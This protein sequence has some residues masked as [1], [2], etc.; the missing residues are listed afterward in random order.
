ML[1]T[2]KINKIQNTR[3]ME[4]NTVEGEFVRQIPMRNQLFACIIEIGEERGRKSALE[5]ALRI[6]KYRYIEA[7]RVISYRVLSVGRL[8][9]VI[10]SPL[11][12]QL[13]GKN[14]L[15]GSL[16]ALFVSKVDLDSSTSPILED[17]GGRLGR[18]LEIFFNLFWI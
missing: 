7:P 18:F 1:F 5:R 17:F 11:W 15:G 3:V 4:T 8:L 16:R 12:G 13:E 2:L 9:E 6:V 14:R 10:L